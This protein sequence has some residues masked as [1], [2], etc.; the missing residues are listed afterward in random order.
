MGE[1]FYINSRQHFGDMASAWT[2][3]QAERLGVAGDTIT[4]AI[5][6]GWLPDE[7]DAVDTATKLLVGPPDRDVFRQPAPR[8]FAS[9]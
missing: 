3:T 1:S 4:A 5:E 2:A 6:R 7:I 8:F 9:S